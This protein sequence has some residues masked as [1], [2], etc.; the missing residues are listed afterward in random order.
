MDERRARMSDFYVDQELAS[1]VQGLAAELGVSVAALCRSGLRMVV[2][3]TAY[4]AALAA[5][6]G[7]GGVPARLCTVCSMPRRPDP[8]EDAMAHA[9]CDTIIGRLAGELEAT[10]A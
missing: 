6:V 1:A 4:K 9:Q 5:R 8:V 2:E 10:H 3:L 7:T